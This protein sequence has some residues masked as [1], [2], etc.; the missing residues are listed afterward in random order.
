MRGQHGPHHSGPQGSPANSR[1]HAQSRSR[2]ECQD[3]SSHPTQSETFSTGSY[4]FTQ[5]HNAWP[6]RREYAGRYALLQE[7]CCRLHLKMLQ[8]SHAFRHCLFSLNVLQCHISLLNRRQFCTQRGQSMS[9]KQYRPQVWAK[10]N[11]HCW[12]CGKQM[13][14][15]DDFTIEHQDARN[16]G[17]GDELANLVPACNS[18]N[19]RKNTKGVEEFRA[20]LVSKGDWRFWGEKHT[21]QLPEAQEERTAP[22]DGGFVYTCP[23]SLTW[24]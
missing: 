2:A 11:G 16:N 1:G 13:N 15:F 12:Y 6:P 8:S 24:L 19:S 10:T 9:Y 20:Y 23:V 5:R 7:I 3:W 14:P 21:H 17:G 4:A 22:D 18:C